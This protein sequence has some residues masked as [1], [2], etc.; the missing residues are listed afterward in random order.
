MC[1]GTIVHKHRKTHLLG[2]E[3]HVFR[4]G[5][6]SSLRAFTFK[7]SPH[8]FAVAICFE[9]EFPE[10]ARILALSGARVLLYCAA[11]TNPNPEYSE[12]LTAMGRTRAVENS[13]F[14]AY[15]NQGCAGVAPK[16]FIATPVGTLAHPHVEGSDD[17]VAAVIDPEDAAIEAARTRNPYL[18]A[19]K[20]QLYSALV[21]I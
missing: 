18:A 7:W 2:P 1:A 14:V 12:V 19:R 17:I 20:P 16:S 3:N 8:K 4:A 13:V 6:G 5:D 11:C 15:C 9:M 21:K 10:I